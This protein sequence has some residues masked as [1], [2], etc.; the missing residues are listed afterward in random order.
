MPLTHSRPPTR[1]RPGPR[2]SAR[3]ACWRRRK[4]RRR[5]LRCPVHGRRHR[6]A[7]ALIT[8]AFVR[9]RCAGETRR[10]MARP[11]TR[12][13]RLGLGRIAAGA[14]ALV[15]V[16]ALSASG[17]LWRQAPRSLAPRIQLQ[18]RFPRKP[19]EAPG[20]GAAGARDTARARGP[21]AEQADPRPRPRRR[22]QPDPPTP[23]SLAPTRRPTTPADF[24]LEAQAIDIGFPLR[25]DT[26]YHYRDNW[27]DPRDRPA[28]S[29]QPRSR[30]RRH[31]RA[32]ARRHRHLCGRGRA[33]AGTIQRH[34]H[35][36]AARW[37]PW[38]P[39]RYGKTVVVDSDEPHEHRLHGGL[40]HL[41]QVWV[42]V[43]RARHARPG[44]SACRPDRQRRRTSSP[45]CTSSCARH[46]CSTGAPRR[47]PPG[48]CVQPVSLARSRPI[49]SDLRHG[50]RRGRATAV[51][52]LGPLSNGGRIALR[53]KAVLNYSDTCQFSPRRAD[54]DAARSLRVPERQPGRSHARRSP[55]H[56]SRLDRAGRSAVPAHQR[57]RRSPL[58][59]RRLDPLRQARRGV[60]RRVR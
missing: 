32:P 1:A 10:Q 48:R 30:S 57:P 36:P 33:S 28:R 18:R 43:G 24:D 34:G 60:V 17:H 56:R 2:R 38:E 12:A 52:R 49:R 4:P 47:G 16:V 35:R 55:Q 50:P 8:I 9:S 40:V 58:S 5:A 25:P 53:L 20:T 14:V 7:T 44:R 42:K 6:H 15:A 45:S 29:V 46:S 51:L 11:S 19:P 54:H 22:P 13:P 59:P 41:D 31:V 3:S 26:S 37:P 39:D 21:N 27:L 23:A